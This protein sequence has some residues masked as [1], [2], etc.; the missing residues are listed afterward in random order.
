M[1]GALASPQESISAA[2]CRSPSMRT[3]RPRAKAAATHAHVSGST[4]T[5]R[6]RRRHPVRQAF[7]HCRRQAADARLHKQVRRGRMA[8]RFR[9]LADFAART[10]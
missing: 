8:C 10:P 2:V 1:A 7:C 6:R 3:T 4:T 9:L 5:M